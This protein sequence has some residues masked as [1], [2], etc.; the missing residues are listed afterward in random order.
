MTV[1]ELDGE[2]EGVFRVGLPG[3]QHMAVRL[4]AM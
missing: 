2:Y 3:R 4:L 1:T